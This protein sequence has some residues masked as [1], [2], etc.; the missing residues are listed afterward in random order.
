MPY[1][2]DH[3]YIYSEIGYNLKNTDLNV[4]IGLAQLDKLEKFIEIRKNNFNYL[5]KKFKEFENYFYLPKAEEKSDP[6]WFGFLLTLKEK[7]GFKRKELLEYLNKNKIG[8]RLLF[9]GNI[10]KQP[11]FLNYNMKY[12]SINELKNTDYIMNNSFWMGIHQNLNLEKM[13][14]I[15]DKIKEFIEKKKNDKL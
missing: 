10:T 14:F 7:C 13:K 2:Y 4:A 1:G 6:S 12:R 3:K 11:Y 5:K 9:A 15:K 8:T